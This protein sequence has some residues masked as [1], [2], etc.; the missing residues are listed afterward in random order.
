MTDFDLLRSK[1]SITV[2][3]PFRHE[4][5]QEEYNNLLTQY[6]EQLLCKKRLNLNAIQL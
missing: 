6:N 2:N 4:K 1:I 3:N 5:M